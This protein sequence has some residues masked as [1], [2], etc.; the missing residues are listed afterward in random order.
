VPLLILHGDSDQITSMGASQR[1]AAAA[2][3]QASFRAWPH[4][5]HELHNDPDKAEVL[6]VITGWLG[7]R[8]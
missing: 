5:F 2:G 4:G 8:L 1:F 6:K 7:A 3:P